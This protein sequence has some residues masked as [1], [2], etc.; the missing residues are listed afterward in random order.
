MLMEVSFS[1]TTMNENKMELKGLPVEKLIMKKTFGRLPP[2]HRCYSRQKQISNHSE[3]PTFSNISQDDC[4]VTLSRFRKPAENQWESISFK[5]TFNAFKLWSADPWALDKWSWINGKN[6][7]NCSI[8]RCILSCCVIPPKLPT[9]VEH[10]T[11]TLNLLI[12]SNFVNS[13][14]S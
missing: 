3:R 8:K 7:F 10:G 1:F 13:C 4:Q 11:N 14:W 6:R 9:E 12:F 5:V 2:Y